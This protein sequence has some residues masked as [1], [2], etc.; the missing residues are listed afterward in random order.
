ML[1]VGLP[2]LLPAGLHFCICLQ[3]GACDSNC[4]GGCTSASPRVHHTSSTTQ[5]LEGLGGCIDQ[6]DQKNNRTELLIAM[7]SNKL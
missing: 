4:T 6:R 5:I 1:K 7:R 2:Q 3:Q